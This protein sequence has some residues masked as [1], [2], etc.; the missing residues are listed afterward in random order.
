VRKEIKNLEN[1]LKDSDNQNK[2]NCD[3]KEQF[4][5]IIK[6]LDEQ[7]NKINMI[8]LYFEDDHLSNRV[9]IVKRIDSAEQRIQALE[10]K[11]LIRRKENRIFLLI[12]GAIWTAINLALKYIKF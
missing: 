7:G 1:C 9:G 2:E 10:T 6:R 5:K 4:D 12:G 3:M 8:Y 11:D